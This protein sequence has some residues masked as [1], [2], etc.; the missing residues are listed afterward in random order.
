MLCKSSAVF[1]LLS[2]LS[3]YCEFP[4]LFLCRLVTHSDIGVSGAVVS[5]LVPLANPDEAITAQ[6]LGTDAEGHTTWSLGPG[7]PSGAFT[8]T[9]AAAGMSNPND[10][11]KTCFLYSTRLP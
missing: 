8:N 11:L 2:A 6:F 1:V 3:H 10:P 9:D 5:L 7:A 4:S